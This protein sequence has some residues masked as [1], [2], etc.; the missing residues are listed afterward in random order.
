M[1]CHLRA[2]IGAGR[3]DC[4]VAS[5]ACRVCTALPLLFR[6][7]LR[8]AHQFFDCTLLLLLNGVAL[9]LMAPAHFVEIAADAFCE[10]LKAFVLA[11]IGKMNWFR[12]KTKKKLYRN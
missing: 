4:R 9:L 12:L 7:A 2:R 1:N 5:C 3:G 8:V 11:K 10:L 6:G